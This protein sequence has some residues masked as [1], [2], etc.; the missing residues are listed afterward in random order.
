MSLSQVEAR[1]FTEVARFL[2]VAPNK[3]PAMIKLADKIVDKNR[4]TGV[5]HVKVAQNDF[6]GLVKESY[7]LW[8]T[9]DIRRDNKAMGYL[10]LLFVVIILAIIWHFMYKDWQKDI[11]GKIDDLKKSIVTFGR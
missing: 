8:M 11:S 2:D 4:P 1:R 5:Q 3:I 9:P 6:V 10:D 7:R